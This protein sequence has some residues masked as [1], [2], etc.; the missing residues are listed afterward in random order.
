MIVRKKEAI[1]IVE[2]IAESRRIVGVCKSQQGLSRDSHRI[3]ADPFTVDHQWAPNI[4]IMLS[5]ISLCWMLR[6]RTEGHHSIASI[7]ESD[8]KTFYSPNL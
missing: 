5:H 8:T 7:G 3:V 6:I 4:L 2:V 1:T